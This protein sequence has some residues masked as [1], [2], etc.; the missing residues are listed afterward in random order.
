MP[1]M[2]LFFHLVPVGR[3]FQLLLLEP[4]RTLTLGTTWHRVEASSAYSCLLDV[5]VPPQRTGDPTRWILSMFVVV[6][7]AGDA[8]AITTASPG[9]AKP[10][11]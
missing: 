7:P 11:A 10:C 3:L 2:H 8:A 9:C 1:R 4:R 5:S 6:F